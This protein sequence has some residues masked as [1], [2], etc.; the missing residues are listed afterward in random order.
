MNPIWHIRRSACIALLAAVVCTGAFAVDPTRHISQY[1]HTVWRTQDGVF[2]SMPRRVAQTIDGYLWFGTIAGLWRF[3]GVRFIPWTPSDGQK[4]LSPRINSLLGTPDGSLW[5]GTAL[6]LSRWQNGHLTN[7]ANDQGVV[8]AIIRARDGTIW[9]LKT[10]STVGTGP[11]CQVVESGMR[12]HGKA[13][14]IPPDGYDGLVQDGQGNFWLGG[15]T[16]LVRWAPDSQTVYNPSALKVNEG[17]SGI[18]GL[19]ADP[20]GSVWAGVPG[21][22]PGLDLQHLTQGVWEPFIAPQFHTHIVVEQ[23]Y[24]D[25][26]KALW[27][28]TAEQGLYRIY[29][30]QIEH[31]GSADGLSGDYVLHFLE[32]HEGDLWVVTSKGV[33]SFRDL[34]VTNFSTREG[35][36]SQEVDSILASKD[37]GIWIG[38]PGS[39][40]QLRNTHITSIRTGQGLPGHLVT[41]LF[42][43]HAG[44]L[45]VGIDDALT[46]YADGKFR[47]ITKR[48]GTATGMIVGITE[49]VDHNIWVESKGPGRPLIRIQD[50]EI[51]EE[52]PT[53]QMPAA[54]RV[55]AD[56]GGGLWLGLMNGDLAR[57]QHGRIES[58]H[59]QHAQDSR[60]EQVTV[61]PDG[62]VLGA[63][64]FG[65]IALRNGKQ[66]TL[67]TRNGL[68]CDSVYSFNSD[69]HGNLWLYSQCGLVEIANADVKKWWDDANIVLQPKVLDALDGAQTDYAPFQG[70]AKSP[71]GRLW[72]ASGI[73][74]QTIDPNRLL[75]N[76]IAPPVHV[77]GITADRRNYMARGGLV[78]PALTRD[79]E[80]DYTA[81]SFVVPQKVRFSYKLEG[82]DTIWQEPG[83]R[84]Q[85]FYSDLRPGHYRFRV[86]ACNNDGVWNEE[87]AALE[88][89][90]LPAFYQTKW[91][92]LFCAAV[93]A[94]LAWM[95]YRYR[96]RQVTGRLDMQF[97]E[98]LSERTRIARELHDTLLQGFQGLMLHFQRARN[99]LPDRA[100]E[101]IQTLDKALD[102]AEQAIV[103]GR[104]AIHDLRSLTPAA[105]G[106][107][108]EITALR[109]E[110]IAE[111]TNKDP[112]Q[113]RVV[114]EGSAQVLHPNVHLGIFRIAREALR[115][116]VIHSG[117]RLIETEIT[118]SDKLFRLRIRDDGRGLDPNVRDQGDRT[119]H[120][121]LRGMRERVERLGG[122]LDI[123][124]EP[125]AGTEVELRI[126]G[127]IAYE[128]SHAQNDF[129]LFWKKMKN[130]HGRP[131]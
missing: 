47:R 89:N 54:R 39:L 67:T 1:G 86:I 102:G 122:A 82:R 63:T 55:A 113:F 116:A 17:Q 58:F 87:G 117:A 85:A 15:D 73:A 78:L 16:T 22:R 30:D 49:D 8:T 35:L 110:L 112:A 62:S 10:P 40:E 83:T 65:L 56:P 14:G 101:A 3:D 25:R 68:P 128:A 107:A 53:P 37:G 52:L 66:L 33:D 76:S 93:T 103:E 120:W 70:A 48:D 61:N 51:K 20:D 31:F 94:S 98:R 104:D 127:S 121:G 75:A 77:E 34:S 21:L 71:D 36:A 60:V 41:S 50:F 38:G 27:V 131:S 111:D 23:L 114:I 95:A 125:G 6:G 28:G 129:R 119:G 115:N 109:K 26:Q 100:A 106:L 96:V 5:I 88:F 45:W 105:Q 7:Y 18:M 4:L 130:D 84:R 97:K 126:P 11:L 80:I 9:I 72:F 69:D 118:Y 57:Y 124:S 92:F 64:A 90:L 19:A 91:F 32:D 12:C 43:D 74:L 24:M 29:G 13:D 81:L 46:V 59:F 99:L 42:E 108:E 79:L 123:W 44:R 2:G